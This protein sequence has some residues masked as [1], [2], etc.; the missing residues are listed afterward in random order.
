MSIIKFSRNE[1]IR[2][3]SEAKF[4]FYR[5]ETINKAKKEKQ[6]FN[7]IRS[8]RVGVFCEYAIQKHL[9]N[10]YREGIV[11]LNCYGRQERL[12]SIHFRSKP[13]I[14]IEFY[15]DKKQSLKQYKIEV[16]GISEGQPKGQILPY[17][18]EK[19]NKNEFTHVAFCELKLDE[20][21]LEAGVEIY[22]IDTLKNIVNYPLAKNK[23]GKDCYTNSEYLHMVKSHK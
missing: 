6:C 16:K 18:A 7:T 11:S 15:D 2:L 17:H 3:E 9:I 1:F 5:W 22:L 20:K 19:Y 4:D 8:C 23:Y 13:D 21:K 14:D 10:Q 12:K